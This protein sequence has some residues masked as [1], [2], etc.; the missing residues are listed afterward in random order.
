M[1]KL[2]LQKYLAGIPAAL[3][4]SS[5]FSF[6]KPANL[7]VFISVTIKDRVFG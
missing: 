1:E 3:K 4:S 5:N 7:R 2:R 6:L